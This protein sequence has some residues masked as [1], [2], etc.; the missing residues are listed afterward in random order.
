M[1]QSH[2]TNK[3]SHE[4]QKM[5]VPC[6]VLGVLLMFSVLSTKTWEIEDLVEV[7]EPDI[8]L[9]GGKK[10]R[11]ES[12]K[13]PMDEEPGKKFM[14]NIKSPDNTKIFLSCPYAIEVIII[15]QTIT[16]T[17]CNWNF[18][19]LRRINA[20]VIWVYTIP[21]IKQTKEHFAS[22]NH[23]QNCHHKIQCKLSTQ[24]PTLQNLS[25]I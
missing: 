19:S 15:I 6:M 2:I 1:L 4:K 7:H 21:M 17:K 16:K 3:S 23:S 8:S 13:F 18:S 12:P 24:W 11:F 9:E 5:K 10:I 14:W 20:L 22:E 25:V